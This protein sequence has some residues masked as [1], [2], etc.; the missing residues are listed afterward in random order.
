M[1]GVLRNCHTCARNWQDPDDGYNYCLV[2][3]EDDVY[4]GAMEWMEDNVVGTGSDMPP[5]SADGCPGWVEQPPYVAPENTDRAQ[6]AS[7][8]D[9][10]TIRPDSA[11]ATVK[12]SSMVDLLADLT[13]EDAQHAVAE[14]NRVASAGFVGWRGHLPICRGPGGIQ[15]RR[16]RALVRGVRR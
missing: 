14:F 6:L 16:L 12:D 8:G 5:S 3:T 1:S 7:L 11:T 13:I 10:A 15:A 9:S 2:R 4:Q